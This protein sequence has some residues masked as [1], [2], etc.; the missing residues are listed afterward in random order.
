MD[1]VAE[2]RL[3]TV[4]HLPQPNC[5]LCSSLRDDVA[6]LEEKAPVLVHQRS[7]V[8]DELVADAVQRL[9]VELLLALQLN[10]PHG[11]PCRRLRDRLSIAVVVFLR[12]DVRTDVLR[13]H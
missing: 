6:A 2:H 1:A 9:H 5:E 4:K 8:T 12:L 13:R 7:A 11:R 10:E 3:V